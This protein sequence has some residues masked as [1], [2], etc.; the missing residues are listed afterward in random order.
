MTP[1]LPRLYLI[2]GMGA[3]GRLFEGL[4]REGL[5]FTVLEFI[6]AMPGETL[7]EYALRLGAMIDHAEPFIVGGVSLGGIMAGEIAI[8]M[9]AEK[10]LLISSVKH[11]GEMPPHFKL[12]RWIPVYKIFSGEWL[13]RHGPRD[14]RRGL[15]P[16]QTKILEDIRTDADDAFITWAVDAVIKW[17]KSRH[18]TH[19]QLLHIHG[20]RDLMFPGI[21]LGK[22]SKIAGGRHV[23]VVTHAAE[24]LKIARP[25]LE[26]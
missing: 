20:T 14:S 24:I 6:P 22:R 12:A 9:G 8:A 23:M 18:L 19:P 16:W 26:G 7:R 13:K 4:A 5:K 3:D 17:R 2:P 1:P 11:S 10:L 25:F 15:A 21:F